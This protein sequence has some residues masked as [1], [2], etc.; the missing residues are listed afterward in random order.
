MWRIFVAADLQRDLEIV[1]V[2]VVP[3][4]HPAVHFVPEIQF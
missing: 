1:G 3:V 4:L 2:Q